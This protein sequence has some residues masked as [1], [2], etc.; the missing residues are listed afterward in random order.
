MS[1][2]NLQACISPK[3]INPKASTILMFVSD[4]KTSKRSVL[5][6]N[7]KRSQKVLTWVSVNAP[8]PP[9]I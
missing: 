5:A 6:L 8:A 3:N 4:D 9:E 2:W 1:S 7:V